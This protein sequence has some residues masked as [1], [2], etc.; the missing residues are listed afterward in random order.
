MARK[1]LVKG[2]KE[3]VGYVTKKCPE[4]YAYVKIEAEVCPYCKTKIGHVGS[5]GMAIR[6][7]DWKSYLTFAVALIALGVY[8][9]WAFLRG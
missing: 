9:W 4:C 7:V 5:H 8:I 2:K 1:K 6:K 3:K